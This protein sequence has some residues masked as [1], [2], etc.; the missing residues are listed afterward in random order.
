MSRSSKSSCKRLIG[1]GHD[2]HTQSIEGK[3][4]LQLQHEHFVFFDHLQHAQKKNYQF[5]E[6]P[7]KRQK[8]DGKNFIASTLCLLYKS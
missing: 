4:L 6:L 1:K 2:K 7:L 5:L 8:A 3:N